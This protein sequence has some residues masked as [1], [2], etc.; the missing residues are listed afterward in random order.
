MR[1]TNHIPFIFSYICCPGAPPTQK[2]F[3][4]DAAR[5]HI[6]R[7]VCRREDVAVLALSSFATFAT[8]FGA[9]TQRY[10]SARRR[11]FDSRF[12]RGW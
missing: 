7:V 2:I 4:R 6:E 11:H 8:K 9:T 1:L 5:E 10:L 12:A 3:G